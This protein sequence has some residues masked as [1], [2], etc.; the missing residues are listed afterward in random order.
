MVDAASELLQKHGI[1]SDEIFYD[2]FTDS[3]NL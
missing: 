3:S 1:K 2:K